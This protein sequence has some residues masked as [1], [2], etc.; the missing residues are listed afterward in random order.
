MLLLFETPA[1]YSLFK[2][3][4]EKR[5]KDAEVR[6]RAVTR[7]AD[8]AVGGEGAGAR[9]RDRRRART[10]AAGGRAR[11]RFACFGCRARWWGG[12]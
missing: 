9:S 5:L 3:K 7:C 2:V 8:G 6:A 10:T 12:G 11:G 1:G 4:D